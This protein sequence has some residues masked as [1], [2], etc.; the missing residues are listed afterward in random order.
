MSSNISG[1]RGAEPP[2]EPCRD[3]T[4]LEAVAE[5]ATL[6]R[7]SGHDVLIAGA[8]FGL[9]LLGLLAQAS[10]VR[11]MTDPAAPIRLS[12]LAAIVGALLRGGTLLA[13]TNSH[14]LHPVGMLRRVTGAPAKAGWRATELVKAP[15]PPRAELIRH[16]QLVVAAAHD[17]CYLAHGALLWAFV[18]VSGFLMWTALNLA[19][20]VA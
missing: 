12:L 10:A 8:A 6:L 13:L 15:D 1:A 7:R 14:L 2:A 19:A 16:V 11:E 9:V 3:A 5:I 17:R 4:P 20:G 18:S